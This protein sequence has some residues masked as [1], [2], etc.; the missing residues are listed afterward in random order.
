MVSPPAP[1]IALEG[2]K[3]L[4]FDF[5]EEIVDAWNDAFAKIIPDRLRPQITTLHCALE[6]LPA[7]HV[8]FDCIVSPANSYGRL[9][10]RCV[11]LLERETDDH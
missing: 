9:D 7:E 6:T 4:F 8:K 2:V 1:A 3:I 5:T 10:G 11:N